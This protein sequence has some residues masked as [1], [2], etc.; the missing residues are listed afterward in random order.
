MSVGGTHGYR[1]NRNRYRPRYGKFRPIQEK[2][3]HVEPCVDAIVKNNNN[4]LVRIVRRLSEECIC[5]REPDKIVC[6]GADCDYSF[7]GRLETKC[8]VHPDDWYLMDHPPLCP[9]CSNKLGE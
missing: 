3:D 7:T 6:T 4:N 5:Q 9:K 8:S 1:G 2:L